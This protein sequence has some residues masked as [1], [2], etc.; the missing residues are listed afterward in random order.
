MRVDS[1][2]AHSAN[3]EAELDALHRDVHANNMAP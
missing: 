1:H 2:L 3:R